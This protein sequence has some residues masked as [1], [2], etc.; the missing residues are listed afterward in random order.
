MQALYVYDLFPWVTNMNLAT[1]SWWEPFCSNRDTLYMCKWLKKNHTFVY[2]QALL[3]K[4]LFR[5]VTSNPDLE[6]CLIK[7]L[8]NVD[9]TDGTHSTKSMSLRIP[10]EYPNKM[11]WC[12]S[13]RLY[14][15][16]PTKWCGVCQPDCVPTPQPDGVVSVSQTASPNKWCL[17]I[18]LSP[19]TP[20]K[21][22]QP[23]YLP[24][25]N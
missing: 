17:S 23:D 20:T 9:L 2:P 22:C 4:C 14:P 25:P 13:T 21:C 24:T 1:Y 8:S 19:H 16:T 3:A 18:R 15:H 12:L 6:S 5:Y 7:I 11:V 10:V